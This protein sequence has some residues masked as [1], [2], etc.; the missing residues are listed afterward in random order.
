MQWDQLCSVMGMMTDLIDVPVMTWGKDNAL[1][2][3][4]GGEPF[5]KPG[6]H[7]DFLS[8]IK[9][10][11]RDESG[12]CLY[13]ETDSVFYGII[14][15]GGENRLLVGPMLHVLMS[16]EQANGFRERHQ[17]EENQILCLRNIGKVALLICAVF[18]IIHGV[19]KDPGIIPVYTKEGNIADWQ[20]VKAVENYQ[21]SQ[22]DYERSHNMAREFEARMI[23]LVSKGDLD[24]LHQIMNGNKPDLDETGI[25]AHTPVKTLEYM[26]VSMV[27]LLTRAAVDGGLN[28]ERAY[29][30]GDVY[31]Q[32]IARSVQQ[33]NNVSM[34]GYRAA[35]DF[36]TEVNEANKKRSQSS[37][38]ED[39][40]GY[41][42][43]NLRKNIRITEIGPAIG[44]SRFY[45]AHRFR[46][47]EGITVQEYII[48]RR[49][50]HAANLLRHSDYSIAQ[51]SEYFC[52]SSPGHFGKCFREIYDLT[53]KEYRKKYYISGK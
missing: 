17:L 46:D 45:L 21:L 11:I 26:L 50:L 5:L 49:C 8:G 27:T 47:E 34:I 14:P 10:A 52:F 19:Q 42:E 38:V 31:L 53:P 6:I 20:A 22:S 35:I 9:A 43:T 29:E 37:V 39:C 4:D 44:V 30:M 18:Y 3:F 51:I 16:P 13:F 1:R 7:A 25:F 36:A 33:G 24:G 48:K 12:P 40:K 28:A 32:L 23:A 2:S 15:A 41:I